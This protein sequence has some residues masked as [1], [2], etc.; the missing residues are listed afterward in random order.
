MNHRFDD[1]TFNLGVQ[2]IVPVKFVGKIC[3]VG[4]KQVVFSDVV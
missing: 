3:V 1:S 4:W 2:I